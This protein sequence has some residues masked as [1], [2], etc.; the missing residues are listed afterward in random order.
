MSR[1][2]GKRKKKWNEVRLEGQTMTIEL[3]FNSTFLSFIERENHQHSVK[4]TI[5]HVAIFHAWLTIGRK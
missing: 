5:G 4:W 2:L 1:V 3:Q